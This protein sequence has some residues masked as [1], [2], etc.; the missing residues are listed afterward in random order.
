[1]QA[2]T[3]WPQWKAPRHPGVVAPTSQVGVPRPGGV[4]HLHRQPWR[5]ALAAPIYDAL[6]CACGNKHKPVCHTPAPSCRALSTLNLPAPGMA[7]RLHIQHRH[8]AAHVHLAPRG[9]EG[10]GGPLLPGCSTSRTSGRWEQ[11][12]WCMKMQADPC[13]RLRQAAKI[14][15]DW[16]CQLRRACCTG[17]R[18]HQNQPCTSCSLSAGRQWPKHQLT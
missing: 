6:Q 16:L 7:A 5:L 15:G 10:V 18:W 13:S 12:V 3:S 14:S 1:M 4:R 8:H 2:P 17:Q 9:T 11:S